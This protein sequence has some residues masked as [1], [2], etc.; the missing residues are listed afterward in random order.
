[1]TILSST[2]ILN[3]Y[4]ILQEIGHGAMGRVWLA[5][6]IIFGNRLVAIKET[7][8]DLPPNEV[9]EVQRRYQQEVQI[10]AA[11]QKVQAPNIVPVYTVEPYEELALLIMAYMPNGDLDHLLRQ[12]GGGLPLDHALEIAAAI[13]QALRAAHEHTLEIVHRDVKPPNVLFDGANKAHLADFGLAQLGGTS[14]RSQL[15]GVRKHPGTPA[16]M[17]P[18]QETSNGYLT[19]AADVYAVGCVLFEMLTGKRYKRMRPGTKPSALCAEAPAWVDALVAKALTEDPYDRFEDAGEM[20][21]ALHVGRTQIVSEQERWRAEAER[22]AEA[23]RQRQ[24]EAQAKVEA[25]R[26][27][28]EAQAKAAAE[29]ER[30][31]QVEVEQQ[32]QAEAE[33]ERAAE[34]ERQQLAEVQPNA[35]AQVKAEVKRKG[36][37]KAERK[38]ATEAGKQQQAAGPVQLAA[39][40]EQP[41]G[42]ARQA[43]AAEHDIATSDKGAARRPAFFKRSVGPSATEGETRVLPGSGKKF[44]ALWIGLSIVGIVIAIMLLLLVQILE[45]IDSGSENSAEIAILLSSLI[46]FGVAVGQWGALRSRLTSSRQWLLYS[47][48]GTVAAAIIAVIVATILSSGNSYWA[49]SPVDYTPA[50]FLQLLC[51]STTQW[52]MLR[53]YVKLAYVWIIGSVSAGTAAW[54]LTFTVG[55]GWGIGGLLLFLVYPIGSGIVMWWLLTRQA[56]RATSPPPAGDSAPRQ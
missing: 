52:L 12:H 44:L 9:E 23:E 48:A 21:A 39:A 30:Q 3:K 38:R 55:M 13:L 40:V 49:S 31:R 32:R 51:L 8:R 34:A 50:F 20:L 5:E 47:A 46:L 29:A 27:Q 25:E 37:E 53:K 6:E 14:G 56:R 11:L 43:L 26:L 35:E 10:Y 22:A 7:R 18:E 42:E 2:T 36:Q 54:I 15:E 28:A 41:Q 17:A 4:K 16:Y 1:M 24:A 45:L 33:R 19:P